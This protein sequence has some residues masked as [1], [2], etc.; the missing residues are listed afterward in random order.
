MLPDESNQFHVVCDAS[1]FAIGCALMQFDDDGRERVVSYQSRQIKPAERNYPV[2]D[3]ELLAIRYALIKFRVYLIGE[4]IFAVYT[5]HAS[6]QTA[7]KRLHLSQH[8]AR[9]LSFFP[10]YNFVV[11]Y[12][13]GKNN[14]LDDGLLRRPD[15]DPRNRLG[16][17]QPNE[18][19]ACASCVA[20]G[21]NLTYQSQIDRYSLDDNLLVYSIDKFDAPRVVIPNDA[22]LRSRIIHEFHDAPI[23]GHLGGEKD[24]APLSLAFFWTHIT[25]W[26]S[27]SVDFVFGLLPDERRRTGVLF[28]VDRFSKTVH[29]VPDSATVTAEESAVHFIDTVFRHHGM[30]ESIV[31]DRD[32]QFTSAFWSK[33]FEIVKAKLKMSTAAHPET[34]SHTECVNRVV[35]NVLRSYATSYQNWSS[36]LALVEFAINNAEHVSPDLTPLFIN[37]ARHHRVPALLAVGN[38]PHPRGLTL[39][40]ASPTAQ[41]ASSAIYTPIP[42]AWPIDTE[43]VEDF[44]FQ[45]QAV[46]RYVR[47]A[48]QAA[49]DRQKLNADKRGRKNTA[50]FMTG[51]R[52]LLSTKGIRDSAVTNLGASKLAPRF[53]GLFKII[54]HIGDSYTLKSPPSI[55]L[56]PTFYVGWLHKY[57]PVTIPASSQTLE[58][59][60]SVLQPDA[61]LGPIRHLPHLHDRHA[62][63]G[64]GDAQTEP[65][66][67]PPHTPYQLP[68]LLPKCFGIRLRLSQPSQHLVDIQLCIK[69]TILHSP[70]VRHIV[71]QLVEHEDPPRTRARNQHGVPAARR[72]KV[73]WLG[74]TPDEDTWEPRANLLQDVPGIVLEYETAAAESANEI[75]PNHVRVHANEIESGAHHVLASESK[76]AYENA[77]DGPGRPSQATETGSSQ[78]LTR[79]TPLI[80]GLVIL[81]ETSAVA[82]DPR[83]FLLAERELGDMGLTIRLRRGATSPTALYDADV[84]DT[85]IDAPRV[86]TDA[87]TQVAE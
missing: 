22:D 59:R 8:M 53:I 80:S 67:R 82:L 13:P 72:Y 76:C 18:E 15:Y 66:R 26:S 56:H 84:A 64:P 24:F 70:Q 20:S 32:P 81:G 57:L 11:H 40:A 69:N 16:H 45:R 58:T 19:D 42:S 55:R 29:F 47:D 35:E 49:V 73:R 61:Q 85:A 74:L 71:D 83:V 12:K 68:A 75:A 2:H 33:L 28:F 79:A 10:Q 51:D 86:V 77:N 41:P 34:N 1:D 52:V 25:T 46:D 30:S 43:R 21:L 78:T 39:G 14:I 23:G 54:K 44:V 60:A 65:L 6:L 38:P 17:Q 9:W 31:S 4:E 87:P 50:K 62:V 27:V 36:F 37:N 5:D 48:L 3:K 63:E 7:M